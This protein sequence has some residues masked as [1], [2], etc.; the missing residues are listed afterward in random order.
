M[1]PA[2]VNNPANR[3]TLADFDRLSQGKFNAGAIALRGNGGLKVVNNHVTMRFLNTT[4][5]DRFEVFNVKAAFVD[6]LKAGGVQEDRLGAIRARLGIQGGLTVNDDLAA[7]EKLVAK[8]LTREEVRDI[9]DGFREELGAALGPARPGAGL[10][11]NRRIAR[12]TNT[13][14]GM[15]A[16]TRDPQV[17][18]FHEAVRELALGKRLG[19]ATRPFA[20]ELD[21]VLDPRMRN[22]PRE[23][24]LKNFRL[25]VEEAEGKLVV[26]HRIRRHDVSVEIPGMTRDELLKRVKE[27]LGTL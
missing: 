10:E 2:P 8:P 9:L 20:A 3:P 5:L 13:A 1:A 19:A 23:S 15:D 24:M 16:G 17:A 7:R 18:T 22:I 12:E 26:T 4:R 11:A 25:Y 14:S 6:A 21:Q 27:L